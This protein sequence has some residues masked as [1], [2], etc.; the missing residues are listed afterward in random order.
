MKI[1][2]FYLPMIPRILSPILGQ[3]FAAA[4]ALVVGGN[5]AFALFA[6]REERTFPICQR[7]LFCEFGDDLETR[8]YSRPLQSYEVVCGYV[9]SVGGQHGSVRSERQSRENGNLVAEDI[10]IPGAT[11]SVECVRR[12]N[13][14]VVRPSRPGAVLDDGFF[15]PMPV[16]GVSPP[17]D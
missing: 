4:V 13:P 7:F 9:A 15:C 3:A 2:I 8:C 1:M 12:R 17:R 5:P 14:P 16:Q 10:P 11:Y 6:E